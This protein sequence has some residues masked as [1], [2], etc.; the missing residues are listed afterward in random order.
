MNF[1]SN[2][3]E[4]RPPSKEK[5]IP[6]SLTDPQI[7]ASKQPDPQAIL[8]MSKISSQTAFQSKIG[9]PMA[10]SGPY[11]LG[12]INK[13]MSPNAGREVLNTPSP[14]DNTSIAP[15]L[16]MVA[17]QEAKQLLVRAGLLAQG[18]SSLHP[19]GVALN[20]L[21]TTTPLNAGEEDW[22]ANRNRPTF[23][24]PQEQLADARKWMLLQEAQALTQRE[25]NTKQA[26]E[27]DQRWSDMKV[28]EIKTQLQ[29]SDDHISRYFKGRVTQ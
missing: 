1:P 6:A 20:V 8:A 12:A 21:S 24:V 16:K 23:P 9:N 10:V 13:M 11:G 14:I 15:M 26:R 28:D 7:R 19:A 27:R 3:P 5:E 18:V 29:S 17:K 2:Y 25:I 4:L 22:V